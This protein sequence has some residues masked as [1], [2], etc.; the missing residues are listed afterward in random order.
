MK[1]AVK[2]N[3]DISGIWVIEWVKKK[4]LHTV[5][6]CKCTS[7]LTDRLSSL[8]LVVPPDGNFKLCETGSCLPLCFLSVSLHYLSPLRDSPSLTHFS[9]NT[10][11]SENVCSFFCIRR[12][13]SLTTSEGNGAAEKM[14]SSMTGLEATELHFTM[15]LCKYMR[16][17]EYL[18]IKLQQGRCMPCTVG[19]LSNLMWPLFSRMILFNPFL[20]LV[21][22][23]ARS[24]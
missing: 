6:R 24:F 8:H 9:Q 4:P 18:P 10:S 2:T 17:S 3:E 19:L 21:Y 16:A 20:C 15:L 12:P 22:V 14:T 7:S 1:L 11:F 5:M 23:T 13:C